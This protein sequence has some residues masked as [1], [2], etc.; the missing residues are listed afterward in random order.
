V[1]PG[2]AFDALA[3]APPW[4]G[5][6][7]RHAP[8][9]LLTDTAIDAPGWRVLILTGVGLV[10]IVSGAYWPKLRAW[11]DEVGELMVA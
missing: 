4:P 6:F 1:S 8:A 9:T 5:C 3:S 11:W 2:L 7:W 10:L